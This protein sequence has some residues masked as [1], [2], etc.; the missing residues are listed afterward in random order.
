MHHQKLNYDFIVVFNRDWRWNG[1]RVNNRQSF[2]KFL[3]PTFPGLKITVPNDLVAASFAS[4][5]AC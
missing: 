1:L 4:T 5:A 2:S 3:F